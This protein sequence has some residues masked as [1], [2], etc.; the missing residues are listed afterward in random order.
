MNGQDRLSATT[1]GQPN[2]DASV[3]ASWPHECGIQNIGPVGCRQQDH[4]RI[5]LKA[6]H[7]G[8]KLIQRLFPF[9]I[10]A[11]DAG[12]TLAA[13]RINLIDEHDAGGFS[14]A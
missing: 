10:A 8:Q 5:L 6:I 12:S 4:S 14:L 9:V 2:L 7:F 13:H 1:V 3:K 11:A